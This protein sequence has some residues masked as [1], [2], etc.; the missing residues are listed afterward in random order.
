MH[1]STQSAKPKEWFSLKCILQNVNNF[2]VATHNSY[3]S[4]NTSFCYYQSGQNIVTMYANATTIQLSYYVHNSETIIPLLWG[5]KQTPLSIKIESWTHI[6][7]EQAP[8]SPYPSGFI[9]HFGLP[10]T[11]SLQLSVTLVIPLR[12]EFIQDIIPYFTVP[13][14]TLSCFKAFVHGINRFV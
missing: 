10:H 14:V 8:N 4:K 1:F 2:V 3:L 12:A 6:V 13:V 7:S 11:Q 5:Y 9:K